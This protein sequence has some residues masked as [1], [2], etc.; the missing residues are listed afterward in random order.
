MARKTIKSLEE[1]ID[2]RDAHIRK[3]GKEKL[4]LEDEIKRLEN[5]QL[6]K[7]EIKL[8]PVDSKDT[9][10][11]SGIKQIIKTIQGSSQ[12]F[13]TEGCYDNLDIYNVLDNLCREYEPEEDVE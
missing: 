7:M 1:V 12:A 11:Y 8:N 6:L 2:R 3:L 10:L 13:Y 4:G 5:N 9:Q